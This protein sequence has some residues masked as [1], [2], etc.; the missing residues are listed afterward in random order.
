MGCDQGKKQWG[1]T[2]DIMKNGA[3]HGTTARAVCT[4][5]RMTAA[6]IPTAGRRQHHYCIT[7]AAP[8]VASGLRGDNSSW[9]PWS[10]STPGSHFST[11]ITGA[12]DLY[13]TSSVPPDPSS[14]PASGAVPRRVRVRRRVRAFALVHPP[15]PDG[16]TPSAPC[17]GS[18]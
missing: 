18:R 15:E 17:A 10:V 13:A 14:T 8:H 4:L 1:L 5:H 6:S 2:A 11:C 12:K 3:L 16:S 7:T 9:F